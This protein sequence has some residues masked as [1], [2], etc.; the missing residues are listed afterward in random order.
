MVVLPCKGLNNIDGEI[1]YI[2]IF[3]PNQMCQNANI[4]SILCSFLIYPGRGEIKNK[5]DQLSHRKSFIKTLKKYKES[6]SLKF[7]NFDSVHSEQ[8]LDSIMLENS[9]FFFIF[10]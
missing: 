7:T 6:A 2:D 3:V 1:R 10:F 8:L 5:C 4:N 9:L